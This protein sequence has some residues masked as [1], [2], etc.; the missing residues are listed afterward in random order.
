MEGPGA[1]T[2]QDKS[3]W[4][5]PN[6]RPWV[7]VGRW[8]EH[9]YQRSLSKPTVGFLSPSHLLKVKVLVA[10]S[11]PTLQPHGLQPTRSG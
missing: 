6:R 7:G 4:C 10:Q 9:L 1:F 2:K 11:C 3:G 8:R 5:D